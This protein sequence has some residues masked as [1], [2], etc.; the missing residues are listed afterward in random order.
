LRVALSL[1]LQPCGCCGAEV[2]ASLCVCVCVCVC[3]HPSA[4]FLMP[5][6]PHYAR[7]SRIL[8]GVLGA[9][10]RVCAAQTHVQ[11]LSKCW[12]AA[13]CA[14]L[15]CVRCCA[16]ALLLPRML[17]SLCR[18]QALAAAGGR[19]R[20]HC[21]A[22]HRMHAATALFA[23]VW[24]SCLQVCVVGVGATHTQLFGRCASGVRRGGCCAMRCCAML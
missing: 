7:L 24:G 18:M 14:V 17:L 4:V 6:S 16:T 22:P 2:A 9:G 3:K 20:R 11:D 23:S 12:R 5:V 15:R 1:S 19:R 21:C 13:C 8:A 10:V